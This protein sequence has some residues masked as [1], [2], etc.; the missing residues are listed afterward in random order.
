LDH[1]DL[2]LHKIFVETVVPMV[3]EETF[4]INTEGQCKCRVAFVDSKT[5]CSVVCEGCFLDRDGVTDVG[6]DA[7][8]PEALDVY[9]K[10]KSLVWDGKSS[11]NEHIWDREKLFSRG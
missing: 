3:L 2:P 11:N 8:T 6:A 1:Q 9:A 10:A 7:T 5:Y 4:A